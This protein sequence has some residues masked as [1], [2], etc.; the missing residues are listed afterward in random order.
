M[1]QLRWFILGNNIPQK[2]KKKKQRIGW[3]NSSVV[4][5]WSR[6]QDT[7]LQ[8]MFIRAIY[9][10]VHIKRQRLYIPPSL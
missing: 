4:Y 2:K 3:Y 6:V 7:E 10:F 5:A 8:E 1:V 9:S